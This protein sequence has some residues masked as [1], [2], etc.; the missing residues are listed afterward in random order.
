MIS[1]KVEQISGALETPMFPPHYL[2]QLLGNC[3]SLAGTSIP[4]GNPIRVPTMVSQTSMIYRYGLFLQWV[5]LSF[6]PW[7]AA[8]D[9]LLG[10]LSTPEQTE[11]AG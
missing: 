8:G 9:R 7:S 11:K 1:Q 4:A 5:T 2:D 3:Q 6:P 10:L